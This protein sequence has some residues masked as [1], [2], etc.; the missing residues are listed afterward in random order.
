M[1][2]KPLTPL[3]IKKLNWYKNNLY[4]NQEEFILSLPRLGAQHLKN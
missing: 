3:Q 2:T 4:H 1:N